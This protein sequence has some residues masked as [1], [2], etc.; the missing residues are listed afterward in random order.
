MTLVMTL[1]AQ[2]ADFR[3]EEQIPAG[4]DTLVII[5]QPGSALP[6]PELERV[7]AAE[8]FTAD[9]GQSLVWLSPTAP[10]DGYRRVLLLGTGEA[11]SPTAPATALLGAEL[12]RLLRGSRAESVVVDV[13]GAGSSAAEIGAGMAYGMGLAAYTFDV[14]KSDK[15]QPSPRRVSFLV[16]DASAAQEHHTKLAALARG[17]MLARDLTNQPAMGLTPAAFAEAAQ[18]LQQHGVKVTVLDEAALREKGMEALLTVGRGSERGPLLVVAH[19]QGSD[20]APVAIIGKGVTFDTGGYNIKTLPDVLLR[21]TS[22]MG[23]AAAA[24]GAVAALAEQKAPVNV[25]AVL[26]LAE[27]MISD[28]AYLPGDV[29]RTAAGITVEVTNT[30]AEGRLIMADAL[31]YARTEF[32][33]RIIIDIATLTGAKAVALGNYYAGLFS[34]D[35]QLVAELLAAGNRSGE[36][37]WRLPLTDTMLPEL[38]SRIADLRNSGPRNGGASVAALFLQQFV[39]ETPFAHIDI[40]GSVL[41]ASERGLAPEGANGFGVQLLVQWLAGK[42]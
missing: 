18:Q 26:P 10:Y 15:A 12:E 37:L 32:H 17:V 42:E 13:T 14:Y 16:N 28:R 29:I 24:L 27:N 23:G 38:K 7:A 4:A 36:E 25:V 1:C 31:W 40:A 6:Q 22:D 41:N 8:G 33:P 20:E 34:R 30:D 21:M 39:G 2:G 11:L 35:E 9:K 19:W 3:F 5:A